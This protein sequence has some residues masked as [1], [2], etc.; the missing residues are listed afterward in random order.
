MPL[1]KYKIDKEKTKGQYFLV[2][3]N[4]VHLA[5]VDSDLVAEKLFKAK[6]PGVSLL[7]TVSPVPVLPAESPVEQVPEVSSKQATTRK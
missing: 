2:G 3:G 7:E 6:I 1:T 5:E 4:R